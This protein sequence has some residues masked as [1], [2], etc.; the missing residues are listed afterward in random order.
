MVTKTIRVKPSTRTSFRVMQSV[1]RDDDPDFMVNQARK[2]FFKALTTTIRSRASLMSQLGEQY[3]GDRDLYTALGYVKNPCWDDYYALYKRTIG[4]TIIDAPVDR[5]WQG[6][7]EIALPDLE[8]DE[9]SEEESEDAIA[10]MEAWNELVDRIDYFSKVARADK[11]TGIG[12]YGVLFLGFN[13]GKPWNEPVS[14]SASLDLLYVTPLGEKS[15]D[16]ATVVQDRNSPRFGKPETY[17][18]SFNQTDTQD[19]DISTSAQSVHWTRIIH[20]VRNNLESEV[21]GASDLEAPFNFLQDLLKISGGSA[22]MFWRGAFPGLGFMMDPEME[23]DPDMRAAMG[24]EI[25][26]YMH[27][28]R[29]YLRLKGVD[30]KELKPQTVDPSK[31]FDV[32]IQQIS[33]LT[34]IP[35]RVLTGT[36]RGELASSQDARSYNDMVDERRGDFAEPQ[37]VREFVDRMIGV[38]VLA[39]PGHY[40]IIWPDL[41]T[42][43]DDERAK[44]ADTMANAVEKFTRSGAAETFL[45]PEVFLKD[46]M[47]YTDEEVDEIVKMIEAMEIDEE[48]LMEAE[49]EDDFEEDEFF[50]EDFDDE[51]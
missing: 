15:A 39:D 14:M 13:D 36:E 5:T 12:K 9:E 21:Y 4:K 32:Q 41:N 38:G 7:F 11:L 25:E 42:K 44:Y 8:Q 33:A 26:E 47:G 50:D 23:I 40:E 31:H 49:L 28:M 16:I 20:L 45:P 6:E 2:D 29:R 1:R 34:R 48:D 24:D 27:S 3:G 30:I 51:D 22:E 35:K 43:T 37:L 19:T 18:I 17:N 46:M 10:W